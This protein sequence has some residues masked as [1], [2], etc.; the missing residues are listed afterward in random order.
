MTGP[1]TYLTT[2]RPASAISIWAEGRD[3]L[4]EYPTKSGPPYIMRIAPTEQAVSKLLDLIRGAQPKPWPARRALK[5]SHPLVRRPQDKD[6]TTEEQR[7]N[8]RA[9]LK[10]M[11]IT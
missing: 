7:A 3:L 9:V 1:D 2:A 11:G 4:V 5:E 6:N 8:A 10:R